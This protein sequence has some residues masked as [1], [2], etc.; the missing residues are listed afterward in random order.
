MS[1]HRLA[2]PSDLRVHRAKRCLDVSNVS[3]ASPLALVPAMA[4]WRKRRK[5]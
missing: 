5:P 2:P 3:K 4:I 1:S